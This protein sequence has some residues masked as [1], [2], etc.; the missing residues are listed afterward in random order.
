MMKSYLNCGVRTSLS[1]HVTNCFAHAIDL[2]VVNRRS[3]VS[4]CLQP[5]SN[6]VQALSVVGPT[7]APTNL[8]RS[9]GDHA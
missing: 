6:I 8:R 9:L 4:I 1:W 5:L 2:A 7:V 3:R